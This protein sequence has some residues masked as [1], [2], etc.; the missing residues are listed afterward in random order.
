VA[1]YFITGYGMSKGVISPDLSKL[2]HNSVPPIPA[3]AAF[4]FH[5]AYGIHVALKRWKVWRPAWAITLI[6]Y[7]TV[8]ITGVIV[9]QTAVKSKASEPS[10]PTTI[11]L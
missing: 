1:V 7:V 4:A 10:A 6:V 9:F 5:S 8:L 2:I 11:E 3:I